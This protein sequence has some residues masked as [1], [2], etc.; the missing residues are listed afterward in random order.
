ML[1]IDSLNKKLVSYANSVAMSADWPEKEDAILA[2][3]KEQGGDN[4]NF[5]GTLTDYG[6]ACICAWDPDDFSEIDRL[7]ALIVSMFQAA[8]KEPDQ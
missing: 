4:P 7:Q 3:Y 5:Q 2:A 6:I 1:D 8:R